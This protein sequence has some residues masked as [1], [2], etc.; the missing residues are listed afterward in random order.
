MQARLLDAVVQRG[1]V[2]GRQ[3]PERLWDLASRVYPG[4]PVGPAE[5]ALRIRDERRLRAL[6][7][8]IALV[9]CTSR[10]Q[11]TRATTSGRNR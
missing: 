3:G 1:E 4:H 11:E 6:A 9:P 2:A 8:T 5:E 10:T 7:L